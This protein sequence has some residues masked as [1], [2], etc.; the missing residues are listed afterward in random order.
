MTFSLPPRLRRVLAGWLLLTSLAVHVPIA[1]GG[2]SRS[3]TEKDADFN[4]YYNIGTRPG[5]PYKDFPVEFP[6]GALVTFRTIAPIAGNFERF[7]LILVII[8][9]AADVAIAGLLT[10]GWGIPAA[11]CYAF[12]MIPLVDLFFIR[13]DLWSTAFATLGVAAWYRERRN[14]A[15]MGFVAGAAY[16]LWPLAFLPL[17]LVPSPRRGRTPS[18]GTAFA[19]GIVVLAGWLW[20]AGPAGLYQVLTFR[21]ATGW[22]VE[23]TVGAIWMLFDRSSVRIELGAWRIG[24]T[25]G[26][27]SILL[28]VLGVVPCLWIV[29][30]GARVG[31]VGAG[32][33]GGIS[34][35]LFMSALLS[36]QFSCWLAP[37]S[38]VAWVEK[39]RRTAVLV[40]LAIFL[41][42]LIWKD[43]RALLLGVPRPLVT[44]MARNLLLAFLAFDAA[45]RVART[46]LIE[47]ALPE[48]GG[49]AV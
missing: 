39:D 20:V 10:W 27:I 9:F 35:L 17:L 45:R 33:A 22:E 44:L 28:F 46:P 23:S 12:V 4:N 11:A 37:A 16:K 42:N 1:V 7:C 6:V 25:S 2:V 34:A 19:A 24:A 31:R 30:R 21:G 47:P 43:F 13:M 41:S 36:P 3:R 40:G 26:P 5:R 18:I 8:N 38:G 49:G 14:L 29:W 48:G 15:A 32:W